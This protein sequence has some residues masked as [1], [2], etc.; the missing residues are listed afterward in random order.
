ME[1]HMPSFEGK[2]QPRW[3]GGGFLFLIT[4]AFRR[5]QTGP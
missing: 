2:D 1:L 4:F 5:L 3:A